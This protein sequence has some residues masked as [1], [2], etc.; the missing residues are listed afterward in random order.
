M[1]N[2]VTLYDH[3]LFKFVALRKVLDAG[4]AVVM[5]AIGLGLILGG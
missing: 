5:V 4:I 3:E 1:H 2:S